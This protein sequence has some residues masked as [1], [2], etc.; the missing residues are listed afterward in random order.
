MLS[1]SP[2]RVLCPGALRTHTHRVFASL[3][4]VYVTV[5]PSVLMSCV[6]CGMGVHR[7]VVCGASL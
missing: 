1:L 4:G 7:P 6:A 3:A 5:P 2:S